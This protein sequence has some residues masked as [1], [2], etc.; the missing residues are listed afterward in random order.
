MVIIAD[1]P[2]QWVDPVKPATI[3]VI[4]PATEEPFARI[5]AGTSED[6]DKAVAAA[7]TAFET[8]SQTTKEERLALLKRILAEYQNRLEDI[9]QACSAEMG[10]PIG[11][12]RAAQA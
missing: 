4:N 11:L 9:A 2:N 8:F 1:S 7:K 5:S 10:A 12:S 3:D 6:V